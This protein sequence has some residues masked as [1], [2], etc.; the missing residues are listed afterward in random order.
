VCAW[1][2]GVTKDMRILRA[3]RDKKGRGFH[4]GILGWRYYATYL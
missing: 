3:E 1:K 2:R 4:R